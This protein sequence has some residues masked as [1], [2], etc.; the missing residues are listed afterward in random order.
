MRKINLSTSTHLAVPDIDSLPPGGIA[1]NHHDGDIMIIKDQTST[2]GD[3]KIIKIE[4][5]FNLYRVADVAARDA[6]FAT[7]V[8]LLLD[9]A[10]YTN[11]SGKLQ[12]DT[13]VSDIGIGEWDILE[14]HE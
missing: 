3:K 11:G 1:M 10:E 8:V 9:M 7:G 5:A 12:L 2:G 4:R 13:L 14:I 6:I